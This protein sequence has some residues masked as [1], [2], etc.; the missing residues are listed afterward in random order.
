MLA[1]YLLVVGAALGSFAGAYAWRLHAGR[2]VVT[3]R[4]CCEECGRRLAARDLVPVLSWLWLRGACRYC[5]ARIDGSA[6]IAEAGLAVAFLLSYLLW[7]L[8]FAGPRQ[9]AAFVVWLLCLTLLTTLAVYD[10][11]WLS[12]PD[13]LLLPLAVLALVEAALRLEPLTPLSYA[14]YVL[15][16]AAI[17]GGGYALL[18][19][20]SGGRWVGFGDAKLGLAAGAALGGPAGLIALAAA[21]IAGVAVLGVTRLVTGAAVPRAIPLGPLLALGFLVGG[22]L[23]ADLD[24]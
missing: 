8:G 14:R 1:T 19:L 12:L 17:L 23:P 15:A 5:G 2:G 10:S 11:R 3:G 21:N 22:L 16:G 18:H 4:S 7:P 20:V 9:V 6:P 13:R 24:S